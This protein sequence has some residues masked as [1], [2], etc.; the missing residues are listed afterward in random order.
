MDR[1]PVVDEDQLVAELHQLGIT[2]LSYRPTTLPKSPRSPKQLLADTIMQ[3]SSRVRT[4]VIAL[5]VLHPGCA[6]YLP[7]ALTL[8][9]ESQRQLLKLFYTAA[10]HLQR[11]YQ[12]DLSAIVGPELVWLPDMFGEEFGISS[13]LS[14]EDAILQLGIKHKEMTHSLTNWSGTYKNVVHHLIR[15]KQCETQWNQLPQKHSPNS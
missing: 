15:H 8:V 6:K 14:S 13:T 12:S 7:N 9:N 3:P 5:F 10:V 2:Y 11:L 4:A 1:Y